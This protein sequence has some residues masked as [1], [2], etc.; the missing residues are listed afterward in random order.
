MDYLEDTL[1]ITIHRV[2]SSTAMEDRCKERA[3]FPARM[4]RW[5]TRELKINHLKNWCEDSYNEYCSVLGIRSQESDSRRQL[6]EVEDCEKWGGWI[7]RPLIDWSVEDVIKEHLNNSVKMN[8]LYTKG[9]NR[10]GCFPCIFASKSEIRL[11]A[12]NYPKQITR[13][14]ELEVEVNKVR[15]ARIK[16]S[17]NRYKTATATFFQPKVRK[18]KTYNTIDEI[19]EWSRTDRKGDWEMFNNPGGCYAW[20]ICEVE[21]RVENDGE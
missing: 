9:F 16:D 17:P 13:L 21:R 6:K 20:G 15:S 1:D 12:D 7:W 8:P 3:R 5:C 11:I 19:V 4:Q 2:G 10:V 18:R 14:R